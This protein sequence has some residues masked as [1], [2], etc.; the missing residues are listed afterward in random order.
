MVVFI[1]SGILPVIHWWIIADENEMFQFWFGPVFMFG[2][3][4]LGFVFFHWHIPECWFPYTF[5]FI[6]SSHQIWH[7]CVLA[8]ALSWWFA[9][10]NLA[11]WRLVDQCVI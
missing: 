11:Q 4:F 2:F 8:A 3:Y 5:D 1:G 9:L 10:D 6:G 7:L